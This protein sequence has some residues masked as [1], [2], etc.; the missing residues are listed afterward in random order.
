VWLFIVVV[1]LLMVPD[2]CI[3]CCFFGCTLPGTVVP[4]LL[5]PLV[6]CCSLLFVVAL[7]R[8]RCERVVVVVVVPL[9]TLVVDLLLLLLV[10]CDLLIVV[11]IVVTLFVIVVFCCL[12][13]ALQC[14]VDLITVLVL[15]VFQLN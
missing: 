13:Y 11:I 2:G 9:I 4:R 10:L 3:C 6:R 1:G 12:D 14:C 8:C 15:F 7:L 5:L